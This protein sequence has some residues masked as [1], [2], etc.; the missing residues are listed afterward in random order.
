MRDDVCLQPTHYLAPYP[1][2]AAC[3]RYPS[4]LH[5]SR[6]P[7]NEP[8]RSQDLLGQLG[9]TLTTEFYRTLPSDG[10]QFRDLGRQHP[11]GV[12]LTSRVIVARLVRDVA[13]DASMDDAVA[14]H[15]IRPIRAMPEHHGEA[16]IVSPDI[17][18]ISRRRRRLLTMPDDDRSV[19]QPPVRAEDP[20][21]VDRESKQEALAGDRQLRPCLDAQLPVQQRGHVELRSWREP[22]ERRFCSIALLPEPLHELLVGSKLIWSREL[23]TLIASS[24]QVGD[25]SLGGLPALLEDPPVGLLAGH[26]L[27]EPPLGD[28]VEQRVARFQGRELGAKPAHDLVLQVRLGDVRPSTARSVALPGASEGGDTFARLPDGGTATFAAPNE[29]DQQMLGGATGACPFA[30]TLHGPLLGHNGTPLQLGQDTGTFGH[31][32]DAFAGRDRLAVLVVQ[33]L[34]VVRNECGN[35][36]LR[37]HFADSGRIPGVTK[38]PLCAPPRRAGVL[39]M[40]DTRRLDAFVVEPAS[41][42]SEGRAAEEV[43]FHPPHD[44]R[45]GRMR[46]QSAVLVDDVPIGALLVPHSVAPVVEMPLPHAPGGVVGFGTGLLGEDGNDRPYTWP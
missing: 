10:R 40:D 35:G 25:A 37:Q 29:A 41:D 39:G 5:G 6:I 23:A 13:A 2:V 21:L 34:P 32:G 36:R 38:R 44:G 15:R 27:R 19:V 22:V 26:L 3:T 24:V 14:H 16:S 42:A 31:S 18:Q 9:L 46:L 12:L 17:H 11:L 33:E 28:L 1:I 4:F 8:E 7:L 45:L 30:N 20:H 43:V